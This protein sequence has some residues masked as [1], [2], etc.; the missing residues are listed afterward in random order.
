MYNK[1]GK[2]LIRLISLNKTLTVFKI[3]SDEHMA[4]TKPDKGRDIVFLNGTDYIDL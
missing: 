4:I 1:T 3:K 2:I